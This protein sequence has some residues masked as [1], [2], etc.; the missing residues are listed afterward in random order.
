MQWLV[1]RVLDG[2]WDGDGA[3]DIKRF[4][5]RGRWEC[6]DGKIIARNTE[7]EI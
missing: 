3:D 2:G 7:I 5:T 6:V 4:S 1:M